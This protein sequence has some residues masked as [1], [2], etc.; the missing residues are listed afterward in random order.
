MDL[1]FRI[2]KGTVKKIGDNYI[3][4]TIIEEANECATCPMNKFCK[5][6]ISVKLKVA[7]PKRYKIGQII[8]IKVYTTK[9]FLLQIYIFI[10]PLFSLLLGIISGIVIFKNEEIGVIL[11]TVFFVIS[12]IIN[13][14]ISRKKKQILYELKEVENEG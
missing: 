6:G 7:D 4:A 8:D 5:A 2:D 12:L 11:G 3:E 14:I 13:I 9:R 1:N 10:M